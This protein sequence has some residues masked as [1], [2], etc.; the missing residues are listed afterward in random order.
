MTDFISKILTIILV[1]LMLVVGPLL[2][3]YKADTM[4]ARREILNDVEVF[5]DKVQDTSSITEDDINQLYIKCNSHGLTVDVTI[6][7]LIEAL[8]FNDQAYDADGNLGV[9]QTNY[10]AVDSLSALKNINAGD[11]IQVN[12]REVTISR[13]RRITYAILRIDEPGL[14]LT[15]AGVVG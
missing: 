14:D 6:K 10:F 3:D 7:R 15:L 12:V 13:Q 5:I 4:M 1:F 9:A 11:I 8:V 2:I